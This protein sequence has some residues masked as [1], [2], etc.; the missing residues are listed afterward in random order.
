LAFVID[1]DGKK[2]RMVGVPPYDSG[3][4]E[5]VVTSVGNRITSAEPSDRSDNGGDSR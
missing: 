5:R 3:G 2:I 1:T 4:I